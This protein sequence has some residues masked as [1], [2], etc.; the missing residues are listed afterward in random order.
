MKKSRILTMLA[1]V[2]MVSILGFAGVANANPLWHGNS[3]W[4]GG[5]G[6]G[7]TQEQ[8]TALQQIYADYDKQAAP[9]QRQLQAKR[10]ELEAL[11]YGG[12]KDSSKVQTLFRETGDI[13]AK[14]FALN[15]ELRTKLEAQ[16]FSGYGGQAGMNGYNYRGGHGGGHGGHRGGGHW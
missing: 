12:N 4:H 3:G 7:V 8:Q 2:G 16:G 9:L 5:G 15:S 13:E 14:L 1:A 6:A 10:A 11:Y